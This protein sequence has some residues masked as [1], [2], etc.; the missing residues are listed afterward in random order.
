M[1]FG[2]PVLVAE[3]SP[4]LVL[5]LDPADPTSLVVDVPLN[6][7]RNWRLLITNRGTVSDQDLPS[8]GATKSPLGTGFGASTAAGALAH[9][10]TLDL[11][12]ADDCAATLRLTFG[13]PVTLTT[14]T[15]ELAGI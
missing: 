9:G 6:H 3:Q 15:F 13:A 4:A 10:G 12:G 2:P 7:A 1:S 8:C 5:T 14:I 11:T